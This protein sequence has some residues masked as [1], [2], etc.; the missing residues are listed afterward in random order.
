MT[1]PNLRSQLA[2]VADLRQRGLYG[3][4]QDTFDY[5]S[6]LRIHLRD[7]SA[8]LRGDRRG[9]YALYAGLHHMTCVKASG[10]Y[11]AR[12]WSLG[13]YSME[14]FQTYASAEG[15][16]ATLPG[17]LV[18]THGHVSRKTLVQSRVSNQFTL[19]FDRFDSLVIPRRGVWVLVVYDVDKPRD[20]PELLY[21]E[22]EISDENIALMRRDSILL[23]LS[24]MTGDHAHHFRKLGINSPRLLLRVRAQSART[25]TG[26]ELSAA[27]LEFNLTEGRK[28]LL[29]PSEFGITTM[30]AAAHIGNGVDAPQ[31][32][33]AIDG[34]IAKHRVTNVSGYYTTADGQVV[35]GS[36]GQTPVMSQALAIVAIDLAIRKV[37]SDNFAALA[38]ALDAH[39]TNWRRAG[40][41]DQSAAL[42]STLGVEALFEA[43]GHKDSPV[44][45]ELKRIFDGNGLPS[46]REM[47]DSVG[48][49]LPHS[50]PLARDLEALVHAAMA[51]KVNT[52]ANSDVLISEEYMA[53]VLR[54]VRKPDWK[55]P[56]KS[57]LT[58]AVLMS[59][60][61][62]TFVNTV[63]DVL[64][65]TLD[66][67]TAVLK[68]AGMPA[69]MPV[70]QKAS[71]GRTEPG[72]YV[73]ASLDD[74]E[75][76]ARRL[77][78]IEPAT[79]EATG[80][81][82]AAAIREMFDKIGKSGKIESFEAR[83]LQMHGLSPAGRVAFFQSDAAAAVNQSQLLAL[84][85][86]QWHAVAYI[87]DTLQDGSSL[88][89]LIHRA[90]GQT[91]VLRFNAVPDHRDLFV[92]D[93]IAAMLQH[94]KPSPDTGA[95]VEAKVEELV[96][97]MET[98]EKLAKT[99][100]SAVESSSAD[101]SGLLRLVSQWRN[102]K[103]VPIIGSVD[104]D[105]LTVLEASAA[106]GVRVRVGEKELV[107]PIDVAAGTI[108]SGPTELRAVEVNLTMDKVV[109]QLHVIALGSAIYVD[110]EGFKK[111]TVMQNKLME[112]A[113]ESARESD[114]V[115]DPYSLRARSY[116]LNMLQAIRSG[117]RAR[118]IDALSPLVPTNVGS[119]GV[120]GLVMS[121][122]E[123]CDPSVYYRGPLRALDEWF[124]PYA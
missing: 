116:G 106:T 45:A 1:D 94:A 32:R 41:N 110:D 15:I 113:R 76:A 40:D 82:D 91:L 42:R 92:R 78:E 6:R 83:R 114:D 3:T 50:A 23:P 4:G 123:R 84:D 24:V 51:A 85:P 122:S 16:D 37:I 43:L 70:A 93:L 36:P 100:E 97:R 25:A 56:S 59:A 112:A 44:I 34:A 7:A 58:L 17:A 79:L 75:R 28:A 98:L 62:D 107:L 77:M 124:S 52:N 22:Y 71:A 87:K 26:V 31:A 61:P 119:P 103:F 33:T 39:E 18:V 27:L 35:L 46:L 21:Q 5:M 10:A 54:R 19:P 105:A 30:S 96:A 117:E 11:E 121:T 111:M 38:A 64:R 48:T 120:Y 14:T 68:H 13:I 80:I 99:S 88:V 66:M 9:L 29:M 8:S 60:M 118:L 101:T 74:F 47:L 20:E 73:R 102:I 55:N 104:N 95:A 108:G 67:K 89:M 72:V 2:Y 109:S 12:G 57:P 81:K 53:A 49:G 115:H 69:D 63:N 65:N 90:G 86:A